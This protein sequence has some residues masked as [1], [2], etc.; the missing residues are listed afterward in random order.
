MIDQSQGGK[1]Y[2]TG[3]K[4]EESVTMYR[5]YEEN[6]VELGIHILTAAQLA[7]GYYKQRSQIMKGPTGQ[8]YTRTVHFI[9]YHL[10]ELLDK[11]ASEDDDDVGSN[12]S[13]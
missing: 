6:Q 12:D 4:F 2:R 1:T 8:L 7:I 13:K 3:D 5:L 9:N 11:K 10:S